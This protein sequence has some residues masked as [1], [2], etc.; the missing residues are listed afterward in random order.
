MV[1]EMYGAKKEKLRYLYQTKL[2]QRGS[3]YQ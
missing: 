2:K 1:S 3:L